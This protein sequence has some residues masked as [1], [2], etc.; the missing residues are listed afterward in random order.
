M[1][2]LQRKESK[3]FEDTVGDVN[4][5]ITEVRK[6]LSRAFTVVKNGRKDRQF[7]TARFRPVCV[8]V[9]WSKNECNL[10]ARL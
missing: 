1:T 7:L 4:D 9:D 6:S 10:T 8:Y 2:S 3:I 5:V